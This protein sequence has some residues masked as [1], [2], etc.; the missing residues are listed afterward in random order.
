MKFRSSECCNISIASSSSVFQLSGIQKLY[1]WHLPTEPSGVSD[2]H[3]LP[4]EPGGRCVCHH[5]VD[6][7]LNFT[8]RHLFKQICCQWRTLCV[9]SFAEFTLF[10]SSGDWST[11]RW[12]LRAGPHPWVPRPRLTSTSWQTL[13]PVWCPCSPRRPRSVH[14]QTRT[15]RCTG[16][17]FFIF[18]YVCPSVAV[19]PQT[20]AT[21][22]MMSFPDKVKEKPADLQNFG[23]RTDMYS[24]KNGSTKVKSTMIEL[25]LTLSSV[26]FVKK[27]GGDIFVCRARVER[28]PWGSGRSKKHYY[29]LR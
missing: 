20:P 7:G 21:Q 1:D 27:N 19:A 14:T 2:L 28:A 24:K 10:W 4:Q 29:Y 16:V 26:A 25:W 5:E 6:V 23:L 17:N 22:P 8:P 3:R 11:T 12:T 9:Y 15:R 13:P 18:F